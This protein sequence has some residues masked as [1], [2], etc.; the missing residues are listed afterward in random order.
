MDLLKGG[1]PAVHRP[2]HARGQ[3]QQESKMVTLLYWGARQRG[4]H[5][6][7]A[8]HCFKSLSSP[9]SPVELLLLEAEWNCG[10][11]QIFQNPKARPWYYMW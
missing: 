7:E 2:G 11:M 5:Y 4:L 3:E 9:R 6:A 10:V 8:H 1:I